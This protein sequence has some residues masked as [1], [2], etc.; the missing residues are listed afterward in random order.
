MP[1]QSS[2]KTLEHYEQMAKGGQAYSQ[3]LSHQSILL[4]RRYT[5]YYVGVCIACGRHSEMIQESG[6]CMRCTPDES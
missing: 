4:P 3:I 5:V 6:R 2:G 1:N